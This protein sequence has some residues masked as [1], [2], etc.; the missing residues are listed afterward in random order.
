M[1][2]QMMSGLRL[3]VVAGCVFGLSVAGFAAEPS[4]E[5]AAEGA[6]EAPSVI[7]PEETGPAVDA[8]EPDA[9]WD[10]AD[11]GAAQEVA[12]RR[13]GLRGG[14]LV[15]IPKNDDF[16]ETDVGAEVQGIFYASEHV[17]LALAAGYEERELVEV[18]VWSPLNGGSASL[19]ESGTS[20]LISFGPSVLVSPFGQNGPLGMELELGLRYV[21]VDVDAQGV[22]KLRS[23]QYGLLLQEEYEYKSESDAVLGCIAANLTYALDKQIS[24][25][26]SVGY[27]IDIKK[28]ELTI[29]TTSLS[30]L[31]VDYGIVSMENNGTWE[32]VD[33]ELE[34]LFFRAGAELR[35]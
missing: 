33:D 32:T 6:T 9:A 15:A 30:G 5:V 13:F 2:E 8:A 20:G 4:E 12:F 7:V 35:F 34:G 11:E 14:A 19:Q 3:A 29:E 24:L 31:A 10:A 21:L 22:Y 16:W 26:G 27:R 23:S 18:D 25:F 1:R 17:A 28:S